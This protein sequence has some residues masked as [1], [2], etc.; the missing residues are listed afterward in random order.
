MKA[1]W[2]FRLVVLSVALLPAT[3]WAQSGIAG[4]VR[5]SSAGILPGVTVEVSSPAL[6]DGSRVTV[7]N[8]EGRYQFVDLRPGPYAVVFTLPGFQ[9]MRR[10]GIELPSN[11]TATVNG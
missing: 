1:H 11:F 6:I 5:D 2:I 4:V 7:T 9:T 8:A 10:E 3:A